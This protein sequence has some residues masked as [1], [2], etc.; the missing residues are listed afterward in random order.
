VTASAKELYQSARAAMA[1]RDAR[2]AQA[3]IA[4][5]LSHFPLYPFGWLAASIH[6][7]DMR[8][9]AHA[10]DAARRG[11]QCAPQEPALLV[12]LVRALTSAGCIPDA[13]ATLVSAEAHMLDSPDML[14]ELG[15]AAAAL[16][17]HADALRL[18]QAARASL[19]DTPALCFNMAAVLRYLGRFAEGERCLDILIQQTPHDAAAHLMRAQLRRQTRDRNHIA[20]LT[21]LLTENKLAWNGKVHL[22]YALAKEYEDLGDDENAFSHVRQGASLRRRHLQY[23]V[24]EDLAAMARIT[25]NFHRTAP[26]RTKPQ[27]GTPC[28]IFIFGLPRSGTTLVERI[29]GCHPQVT[30]LGEINDFPLSVIGEAS[31]PGSGLA[32]FELID[33]AARLPAKFFGAAYRKR[34]VARTEGA[35]FITDKLPMNY[36]YAGLIAGAL[37]EARLVLVLRHPLANGYG[38]YKTLF[39]QGYPFSYDL[40]EIGRYMAAYHS[41]V[42]HWRRCLGEALFVLQYE[43]LVTKREDTTRALLAYCGLGWDDACLHPEANTLPATTQSAVQVRERVH[44]RNLDT[45]RNVQHHLSPLAARLNDRSN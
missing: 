12:Q 41:L 2:A 42:A 18:M 10:V 45:W 36:L 29:L 24:T 21:A 20:T 38:L 40:D 7:L 6:A 3:A 13:R 8:Q 11:L 15:N 39:H 30:P 33:A 14:H 22:H 43:D 28:P 35:P 1:L 25:S 23:D 16:D 31:P 26:G 37:P 9:P 4:Q 32:K 5:L 27:A 44:G 17:L 34:I 19:G